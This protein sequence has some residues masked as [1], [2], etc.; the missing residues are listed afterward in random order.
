LSLA[1]IRLSG[2]ITSN[3]YLIA[4]VED[5]AAVKNLCPDNFFTAPEKGRNVAGKSKIR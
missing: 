1:T 5:L 3:K 4:T 2:N